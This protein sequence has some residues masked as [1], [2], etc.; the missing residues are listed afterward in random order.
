MGGPTPP[1]TATAT[2]LSSISSKFKLKNPFE[3]LLRLS[4]SKKPTPPADEDEKSSEK[5]ER[6]SDNDLEEVAK[7]I[8][9]E[10]PKAEVEEDEEMPDLIH[11]VEE[12]ASVRSDEDDDDT[13]P[14]LEPMLI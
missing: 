2:N 6:Q 13:P 14:V 11:D 7:E 9:D 4:M 3:N 5:D 1:A 8:V 12:R 10:E